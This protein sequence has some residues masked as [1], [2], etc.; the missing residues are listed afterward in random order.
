MTKMTKTKLIEK[1]HA[2]ERT[3]EEVTKDYNIECFIA[4][5][6]TRLIHQWKTDIAKMEKEIDGHLA[7]AIKFNNE[8]I[9]LQK[10]QKAKN[11]EVAPKVE[12]ITETEDV[13]DNAIGI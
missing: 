4:G 6:Q 7:N 9:E 10:A 2:K 13:I 12:E 3:I 11:E 1:G 5:H 8:A